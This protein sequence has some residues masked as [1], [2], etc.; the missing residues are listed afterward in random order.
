MKSIK[1][2]IAL[3]TVMALCTSQVQAQDYSGPYVE[4]YDDSV[5]ATDNNTAL[6]IG[7]A[8]AAGIL[9]WLLTHHHHHHHHTTG[10]TTTTGTFSH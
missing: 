10:T 1:K 9:I 3:A 7:G 6:W 8:V 5:S 2:L 4:A